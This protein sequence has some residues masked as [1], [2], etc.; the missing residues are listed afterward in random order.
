M[1]AKFG[2]PPPH[3]LNVNSLQI[4]IY[5]QTCKLYIHLYI[6]T[7]INDIVHKSRHVWL[8]FSCLNAIVRLFVGHD[9]CHCNMMGQSATC[10]R[11]PQLTTNI[12]ESKFHIAYLFYSVCRIY[13]TSYFF[14]SQHTSH[15]YIYHFLL[16]GNANHHAL[17]QVK[18][19]QKHY[20]QL[21][22]NKEKAECFILKGLPHPWSIQVFSL[23]K[24]YLFSF[25]DCVDM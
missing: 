13:S 16:T 6:D 21:N 9:C 18:M 20:C 1:W 5:F 15:Q 11:Q 22:L 7:S 4:I 10:S 24:L 8:C 14:C 12:I 23:A 19:T 25:Q 2:R 3:I 17:M